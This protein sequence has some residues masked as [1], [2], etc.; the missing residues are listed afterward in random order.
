MEN[1]LSPRRHEVLLPATTAAPIEIGFFDTPGE[2]Y[3]VNVLGDL[4][5]VADGSSG[6]RIIDVSN[7]QFPVELG[8]GDVAYYAVAVEVA[9][10]FAYVADRLGPVHV[11][12]VSNP[13]SP[14]LVGLVG[15]PSS[16]DTE[17]VG[18]IAY[19]AG[20]QRLLVL[21]VVD[22]AEPVELGALDPPGSSDAP[23]ASCVEVVG[24]V[25]FLA[26]GALSVSAI[27][28][29]NPATPFEMGA[30]P[31]PGGG[32]RMVFEG[33]LA[34]V[35]DHRF[36]LRIIDFGPEYLPE[37]HGWTTLVTAAAMLGFL[38]RR[39]RLNRQRSQSG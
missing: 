2:A 11:F 34:Y 22:P 13:N 9:N 7:P 10:G 12:D 19:V 1:I 17:V 38:D 31:T 3:A 24:D 26:G 4:A 20:P 16:S 32:Q 29:A 23:V 18:D 6:L 27:D 28:V 36:G 33:G 21:D 5:Y 30:Y 39:R 37:P 14:V 8:S 15:G 25:A 35:A